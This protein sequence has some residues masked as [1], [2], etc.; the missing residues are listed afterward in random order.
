MMQLVCQP[1]QRFVERLILEFFSDLK[2]RH[3]KAITARVVDCDESPTEAA[4]ALLDDGIF[5]GAAEGAASEFCDF[6]ERLSSRDTESIVELLM[7]ISELNRE[8]LEEHVAAF[9]AKLDEGDQED[10]IAEFWE[11]R[12]GG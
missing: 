9:V 11:L 1:N 7:E 8:T 3:K 6:C 12:L 4:K 5:K 10:L 2:P